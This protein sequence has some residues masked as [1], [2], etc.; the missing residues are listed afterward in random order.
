MVLTLKSWHQVV[1]RLHRRDVKENPVTLLC[2]LFG[3]PPG[4][5]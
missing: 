4:L 1:D 5:L 2:E 3:V